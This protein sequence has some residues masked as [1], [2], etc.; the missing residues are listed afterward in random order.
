MRWAFLRSSRPND[1][2]LV[3]VDGQHS[4]ALVD[5]ALQ[6]PPCLR[7]EPRNHASDVAS[8]GRTLRPR[9]VLPA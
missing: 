8:G 4:D 6:P 1:R 9:E 3:L 2:T 7:V 5:G